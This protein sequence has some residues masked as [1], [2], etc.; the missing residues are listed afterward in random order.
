[1]L[2]DVDGVATAQKKLSPSLT[3]IRRPIKIGC[4]LR[5]AWDDDDGKTLRSIP[6]D[7]IF[8]VGLP[9]EDLSIS[10]GRVTSTDEKVSLLGYFQRQ[11]LRVRYSALRQDR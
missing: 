10:N 2:H 8:N 6:W 11:R 5:P 3:T 7:L 4:R 1:L 9:A